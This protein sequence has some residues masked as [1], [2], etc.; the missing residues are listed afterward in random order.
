MIFSFASG[1]RRWKILNGPERRLKCKGIYKAA[2]V[3]R[4]PGRAPAPDEVTQAEA[5]A[6]AALSDDYA[7]SSAKFS[8]QAAHRPVS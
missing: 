3:R 2:T 8:A 1:R 4:T 7:G 5:R 6:P